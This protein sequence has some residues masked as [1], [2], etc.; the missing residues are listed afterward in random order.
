MRKWWSVDSICTVL[1]IR[2]VLLLQLDPVIPSGFP[3]QYQ[4][5]QS[6]GNYRSCSRAFKISQ[7]QFSVNNA[8]EMRGFFLKQNQITLQALYK[9]HIIMHHWVTMSLTL[10]LESHTISNVQI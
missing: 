3:E 5:L 9:S 2:D 8:V 4:E 6:Q 7:L 1:V 10:I